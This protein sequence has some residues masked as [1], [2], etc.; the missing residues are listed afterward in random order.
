MI[1]VIDLSTYKHLTG[2]DATI[3]V[4]LTSDN[5]GVFP[6]RFWCGK[7]KIDKL[8][9]FD[10][11]VEA[12]LAGGMGDFIR[13][14]G[15]DFTIKFYLGPE[16]AFASVTTVNEVDIATDMTSA[17]CFALGEHR[18]VGQDG[19]FLSTLRNGDNLRHF[20]I[21][22]DTVKTEKAIT[23]FDVTI[24]IFIDVS[25]QAET[26]HAL[27]SLALTYHFE[28]SFR[29]FFFKAPTVAAVNPDWTFSGLFGTAFTLAGGRSAL[30][31]LNKT[32]VA[33]IDTTNKSLRC[34]RFNASAWSLVGSG[35]S[36]TGCVNPA[37]ARLNDTDVAFI[38][39]ANCQLRCYRFNGSTWSLIGSGVTIVSCGNP[40]L[41]SLG[42]NTVVFIGDDVNENTFKVFRFD[43]SWHVDPQPHY[44]SCS[45]PAIS[46]FNDTD[47][48]IIDSSGFIRC[49]RYANNSWSQIGN[50]YQTGL[51]QPAIAALN[52]TDVAVTS[53]PGG[54]LKVLRFDGTNWT[55]FDTSLVIAGGWPA[56]AALNGQDVAF[57]DNTVG[58][59]RVYR[60]GFSI[61]NPFRG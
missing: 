16:A 57:H 7:F 60:I 38:D 31:A 43:G 37:L 33:F 19:G 47:F 24:F 13:R 10:S 36:I 44:Y 55:V 39:S 61:G 59:L 32:N 14:F 50:A 58:S 21:E 52:A 25:G 8:A 49:F 30:A 18:S 51:S 11:K 48:S 2:M 9:Q 54:T 5:R 46:A 34:Y 1:P 12:F 45:N 3:P 15:E 22:L 6:R 20:S 27:S 35:L 40:A 56:L 4:V 23:S 42:N 41:A 26:Y 53:I 28:L 17:G 29:R